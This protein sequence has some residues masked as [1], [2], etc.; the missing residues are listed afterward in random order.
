MKFRLQNQE[1]IETMTKDE[2][3]QHLKQI[4]EHTRMFSTYMNKHLELERLD[5]QKQQQQCE[6][7]RQRKLERQKQLEEQ[8]TNEV[9]NHMCEFNC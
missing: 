1:R 3:C 6:E 7:R 9:N 5:I 8:S 2:Y 4:L